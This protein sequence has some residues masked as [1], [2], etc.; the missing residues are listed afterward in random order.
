M[1]NG[2]DGIAYDHAILPHS[3]KQGFS[4]LAAEDAAKAKA[5]INYLMQD[6]HFL[7]LFRSN[8]PEERAAAMNVLNKAHHQAYSDAP[9]RDDD[10]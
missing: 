1:P 10:A 6:W 8:D 4:R 7:A 5:L 3:F 2:R 9:I